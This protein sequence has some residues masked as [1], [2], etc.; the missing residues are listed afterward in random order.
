MELFLKESTNSTIPKHHTGVLTLLFYRNS[1][2]Q[3]HWEYTD[4]HLC[5]TISAF[6]SDMPRH[7]LFKITSET[8]VLCF[9]I[10]KKK[11]KKQPCCV[12]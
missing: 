6:G 7:F 5:P 10:K 11:K 8:L 9:Q 4:S 2:E 12:Y 1:E 3:P